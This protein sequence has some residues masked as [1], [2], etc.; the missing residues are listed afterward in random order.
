[1]LTPD[2]EVQ[3]QWLEL[4]RQLGVPGLASAVVAGQMKQAAHLSPAANG[5]IDDV[6]VG[7]V[8]FG[9]LLGAYGADRCH[10][11]TFVE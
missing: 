2:V 4:S 5:L 1:M 8:G 11:Q 6:L 10:A 7:I 3:R 9:D